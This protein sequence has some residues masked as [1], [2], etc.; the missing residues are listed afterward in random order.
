MEC[1]ATVK[2]QERPINGEE[3]S[4]VGILNEISRWAALKHLQRFGRPDS[5]DASEVLFVW[6]YILLFRGLELIFFYFPIFRSSCKMKRRVEFSGPSLSQAHRVNDWILKHE[7]Q[8][9]YGDFY[10]F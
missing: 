1:S 9:R 6:C 8:I 2:Q 3:D 5:F 7:R 10:I 4:R